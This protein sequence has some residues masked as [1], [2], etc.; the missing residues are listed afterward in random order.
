M[1]DHTASHAEPSMEDILASIRRIMDDD[2]SKEAASERVPVAE[3]ATNSAGDAPQTTSSGAPFYDEEADPADET[4]FPERGGLLW[5]RVAG[6]TLAEAGEPTAAESLELTD[7]ADEDDS[8]V[9][10]LNELLDEAAESDGL[11]NDALEAVARAVDENGSGSPEDDDSLIAEISD[12]FS[13]PD[14]IP[15][16]P[17]LPVGETS[18]SISAIERVAERIP[19][20]D[21]DDDVLDLTRRI[22]EDGSI[23]DIADAMAGPGEESPEPEYEAIGPTAAVASFSDYQMAEPAESEPEIDLEE[24]YESVLRPGTGYDTAPDDEH[25]RALDARFYEDSYDEAPEMDGDYAS[26]FDEDAAPAAA[27]RSDADEL[28][29]VGGMVRD[30][31]RNRNPAIVGNSDT[32]IISGG[33]EESASRAL[34]TL[35]RYE[36][37]VPRRTYGQL[38]ITDDDDAPTVDAVVRDELRPMLREWL[39]EN[40]PTVVENLVKQEVERISARSRRFVRSDDD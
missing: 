12:S 32:A 20:G 34:A 33:A 15:M 17:P 29:T 35:A 37:H 4:I 22:G 8:D 16:P 40:L 38:R 31:L 23:D 3:P 25:E 13:Q 24:S 39:N 7:I 30:A 10:E 19:D 2:E 14:P 11:D 18:A 26:T 27:R 28:D 9:Y 6:R 36:G 1:T 21:D 5:R